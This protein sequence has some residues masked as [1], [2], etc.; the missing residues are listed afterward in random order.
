MDHIQPE[1][2]EELADDTASN[3]NDVRDS[4]FLIAELRFAGQAA[5]VPVRVR[6]I[7][8]GG[9][10]AEYPHGLDQGEAVEIE[11][12]NIGWVAGRIAWSAAGRVGIAFNDPIDPL[13]ARKPVSQSARKG[14]PF[15]QTLTRH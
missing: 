6:N 5:S 3:R 8:S 15:R 2:F 11:V 10:M 14:D 12:R 1:P 13:V 7:S 9:L 4:M